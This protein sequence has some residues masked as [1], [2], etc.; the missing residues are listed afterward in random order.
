LTIAK[1]I[2]MA[3]EGQSSGFK[4]LF[5]GILFLVFLSFAGQIFWVGFGGG[6]RLLPWMFGHER[7]M[8]LVVGPGGLGLRPFLMVVPTFFLLLAWVAI[9]APLVYRD[10]K[11]HGM[12]PYLWATI[13]TFIPFFLGVIVYLVVRSSNGRTTCAN[14]GR[15]IHGDY[16]VCPYCG[17]GRE[18]LC[19][20]CAKPV[21]SDWKTCPYCAHT[22]HPSS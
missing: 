22:L 11:K 12:D 17:H 15:P 3:N 2:D 5:W 14:C 21:A 4:Y 16:K 6:C 7:H 13:A 18:L 20:A 1:E 9:V 19:P 10:A 8:P